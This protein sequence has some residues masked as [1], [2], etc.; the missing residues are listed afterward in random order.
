ML[1]KVH[2]IFHLHYVSLLIWQYDN[3]VIRNLFKSV[4]AGMGRST[5]CTWGKVHHLLT[6]STSFS[7][8]HLCRLLWTDVAVEDLHRTDASEQWKRADGK[9][10]WP[11]QRLNGVCQWESYPKGKSR[12][13]AGK[14]NALSNFSLHLWRSSDC[15]DESQRSAVSPVQTYTLSFPFLLS[16]SL[17][18]H[19]VL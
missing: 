10:P 1:G 6:S 5:L 17:S 16:L 14:F 2:F 3:C 15:W 19:N 9:S 8:G 11:C 7:H 4:I 18:D 13:R 12:V